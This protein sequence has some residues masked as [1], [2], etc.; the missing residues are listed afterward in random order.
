MDGGRTSGLGR[1]VEGGIE[2]RRFV[3]RARGVR[4]SERR[5]VMRILFVGWSGGAEM[6]IGLGMGVAL[7]LGMEDG[8]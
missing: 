7:K 2:I 5:N 3:A 1:W 6:W 4:A 8:A